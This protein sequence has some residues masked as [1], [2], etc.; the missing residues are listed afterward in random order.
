[1]PGL[2]RVTPA[3]TADVIAFLR[4]VDLT[5]AGIGHDNVHLWIERDDSNSIIASTGYERDGDHALIRSVAVSESRRRNGW[6]RELAEIALTHA[7][8]DGATVAWLFS[9]RS[10][11]FWSQLGFEQ[12]TSAALAAVLGNTSQVRLFAETG[13]LERETAWSRRL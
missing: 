9:R 10:G 6:G 7:G 5:I 11:A 13:Q 12:T 8:Q 4:E 1:M 2:E 3:D